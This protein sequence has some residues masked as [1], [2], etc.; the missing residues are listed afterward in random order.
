MPKITALKDGGFIIAWTA[1][2]GAES[3]GSP[4]LDIFLQRFDSDGNSVGD[5]VHLDK[6]GDQGLFD[7]SIATLADGRVIL[8]YGSETGDATNVTTLNYRFLDP[9]DANILGTNAADNVVSREDG[10]T[11][12]GSTATTSSPA[13]QPSMC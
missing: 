8:T 9:R 2:D 12:S 13:G 1:G 7:M 6:P 10:A 3:D 11:I 4:E 5:R